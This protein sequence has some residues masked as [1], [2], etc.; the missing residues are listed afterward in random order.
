MGHAPLSCTK[1]F[2]MFGMLLRHRRWNQPHLGLKLDFQV[3]SE[4]P[5]Y[6]CFWNNYICCWDTPLCVFGEA[7]DDPTA[8]WSW[9]TFAMHPVEQFLE[10]LFILP[11]IQNALQRPKYVIIYWPIHLPFLQLE[12]MGRDTAVPESFNAP[13]AIC[14]N[15]SILFLGIHS[16]S[17]A[18][19]RTPRID[20]GLCCNYSHWWVWCPQGSWSVVI[21]RWKW[22]ATK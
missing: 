1:K 12:K 4:L 8:H 9:H 18:H 11:V 16:S 20:L 13:N 15:W 3:P 2:E 22:E 7:E 21:Q 14:I 6:K 5:N 17:S 10:S 19:K